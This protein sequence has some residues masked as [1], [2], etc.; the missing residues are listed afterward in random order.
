MERP[1][2]AIKKKSR[3][4]AEHARSI[5]GDPIQLCCQDDDQEDRALLHQGLEANR[6]FKSLGL[7][8]RG[9]AG[10]IVHDDEN[11]QDFKALV[12]SAQQRGPR[13]RKWRSE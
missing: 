13:P 11:E 8:C 7:E 6:R 2:F 3:S 1:S 4:G 10:N 5:V 12:P 9:D